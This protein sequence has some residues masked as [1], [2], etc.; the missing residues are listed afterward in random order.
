MLGQ[1]SSRAS[2]VRRQ[3][4]WGGRETRPPPLGL[5][6]P[7]RVSL[8]TWVASG[9]YDAWSATRVI[10][11][12]RKCSSFSRSRRGPSCGSAP[13]VCNMD[14]LGVHEGIC[15]PRIA[16]VQDAKKS[17]RE[18]SPM[19]QAARKRPG[20]GWPAGATWRGARQTSVGSPIRPHAVVVS[21]T[22]RSTCS[23]KPSLGQGSRSWV[24]RPGDP[25]RW[26]WG[27]LQVDANRS[28]IARRGAGDGARPGHGRLNLVFRRYR[29]GLDMTW[30]T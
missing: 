15:T 13:R 29:D 14:S 18:V 1:G 30:V 8:E 11:V 5:Q 26:P 3:L 7:R 27:W 20:A 25:G 24:P 9:W 6:R 21:W 2:G 4:L 12:S 16:M 23:T 17:E 28:P 10:S 19:R 22:T